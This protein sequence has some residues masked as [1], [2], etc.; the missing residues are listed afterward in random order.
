LSDGWYSAAENLLFIKHD[1]DKAFIM[2]LKANR[3]VA[4]RAQA[5]RAD[6]WVRL[7]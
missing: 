4:H 7:D 2:P 1:L 6:K 3:K 5:K